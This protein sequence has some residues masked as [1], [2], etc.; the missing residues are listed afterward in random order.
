M[1]VIKIGGT[2]A[3]SEQTLTELFSEI[4]SLA[5]PVVLVHGGGKRVTDLSRRLGIEP[6]FRD[7]IRTTTDEEMDLVDMGLAGAVN[8][9]LV[10]IAGRA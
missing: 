9:F 8:T 7:G 2:A 6:V 3:E 10:R 4:E 5:E 1:T